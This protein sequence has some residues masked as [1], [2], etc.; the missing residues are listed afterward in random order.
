MEDG[1]LLLFEKVMLHSIYRIQIPDGEFITRIIYLARWRGS[2][3]NCC[4]NTNNIKWV[5]LNLIYDFAN[6]ILQPR[7]DETFLSLN[8]FWGSE[9][10]SY[11]SNLKI[12]KFSSGNQ[13]MQVN[14]Q[15]SAEVFKYVQRKTGDAKQKPKNKTLDLFSQFLADA[16]FGEMDA[17]KI[18]SDFVQHCYPSINMSFVSFNDYCQRIGLASYLDERISLKNVFKAM[19]YKV[20]NYIG[21]NELL[22]GLASIDINSPHSEA[23]YIYIFRFYDSDSDGFL[24]RDD[25]RRLLNDVHLM[26]Q[27][28]ELEPVETM[29]AKMFA[30]EKK[31]NYEQFVTEINS[32]RLKGTNNLC[33][34][35]KPIL[36][37]I[38]EINAY[39][40]IIQKNVAPFGQKI[41]SSCPKCRPK[42]YSLATHS[43]K[44]TKTG[45]IEEPKLL[46][47]VDLQDGCI[48]QET[49]KSKAMLRKHSI[50]YIFKQT[51][52]SNY[53][54]GLIRKMAGYCKM[55]EDKKKEVRNQVVNGLSVNCLR[56]LCEEVSEILSV[57]PRVIKVSTPTFV[58]GD[59]HGNIND[60]LIFE[61]QLWPMAPS[62]NAPSV[63]FLGDYVDRGEFGI[64]VVSYLFAMKTLAPN[65][66]FLLRGNH[67]VR[68]I[69]RSFTFEKECL[70][71]YGS[72][73]NLVFETLNR[74]FDMLPFCALIDESIYCAHGG[75][76]FTQTKIEDLM[77][78]PAVLQDP[79]QEA[80]AVWEVSKLS[81]KVLC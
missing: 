56:M 31:M 51:S 76:P 20:K 78:A 14:E 63:L 80:P 40:M 52:N 81:I 11:A 19:N 3:K 27:S 45:R 53:V 15:T 24:D 10:I 41:V 64:E 50:E 73:G 79:E 69:Q 17:V 36:Q 5:P 23:R 59:I 21:F 29:L 57:E 58:L 39:E 28:L 2:D 74:V 61:E 72:N 54:L 44:L 55:T 75:I 8:R 30:T 16:H 33:R 66:F 9:V 62:A 49:I 67:E 4:R 46:N 13:L 37:I 71:K 34:T 32:Q 42:Y 60:L 1:S 12:T 25:V 35:T 26:N 68:A 48:D 6:G 65:K 47:V 7:T 43:V 22:I 38:N 70:E 18:Y 77:R